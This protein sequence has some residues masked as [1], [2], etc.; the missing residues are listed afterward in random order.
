[1]QRAEGYGS[2]GVRSTGE[3]SPTVLGRPQWPATHPSSPVRPLAPRP[4][5]VGVDRV[6]CG[7]L[8]TQPERGEHTRNR[9]TRK[10][11]RPA[12]ILRPVPK[13]GAPAPGMRTCALPE[14]PTTCRIV[15]RCT[16]TDHPPGGEPTQEGA[17]SPIDPLRDDGGGSSAPGWWGSCRRLPGSPTVCPGHRSGAPV[18][19]TT[20]HSP[21][22]THPTNPWVTQTSGNIPPGKQKEKRNHPTPPNAHIRNQINHP[23]S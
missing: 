23:Q 1:M 20:G 18:R 11:G 15:W 4:S 13:R 10:H 8:G 9:P 7:L 12:T 14:L 21:I 3:R 22:R 16:P 2:A 19:G 6:P 17:E 5:G